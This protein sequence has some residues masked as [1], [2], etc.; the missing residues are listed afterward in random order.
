MNHAIE[1]HLAAN[2]DKYKA[3]MDA[4]KKMGSESLGFIATIFDKIKT[5]FSGLWD[6]FK[7]FFSGGTDKFK[8]A[9]GSMSDSASGA[10]QKISGYFSGFDSDLDKSKAKMGETEQQSSSLA[11]QIGVGLV[12]AFVAL[13]AAVGALTAKGLAVDA[14]FAGIDAS[15]YSRLAGITALK[16]GFAQIGIRHEQVR[17]FRIDTDAF[18]LV[19]P[20]GLEN[21]GAVF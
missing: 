13:S 11:K 6:S 12:A 20:D 4:A 18:L 5:M 2:V 16:P 15:F 17:H 8:S 3:G 9:F 7:S 19:F 21:I 1:V 14:M 10:F